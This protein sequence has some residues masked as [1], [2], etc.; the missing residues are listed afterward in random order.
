[1]APKSE[2]QKQAEIDELNRE[3]D[4]RSGRQQAYVEQFREASELAARTAMEQGYPILALSVAPAWMAKPGELLEGSVFGIIGRAHPEY[5]Q[6]PIVG[7]KTSDGRLVA[8][9]CLPQTLHEGMKAVAPQVGQAIAVA[10]MGERLSGA[11]NEEYHL[12]AVSTP[13]ATEKPYAW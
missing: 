1:M 12:Y 4:Q 6:Y 8:V 13:D 3:I 5:G 7:V 10:F 2:I 11:R 9:H